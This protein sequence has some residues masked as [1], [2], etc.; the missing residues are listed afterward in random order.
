[1]SIAE[2]LVTIA[3]NQ[4][5]VYEAGYA[6]GRN[7]TDTEKVYNDGV[8]DGKEAERNSFWDSYLADSSNFYQRF[9]GKGFSDDNFYPT[10]DI[11]VTGNASDL[12]RQSRIT[13]LEQRLKECGVV[14]D[15]S[16]V[17]AL[18]YAFNGSAVTRLPKIDISNCTANTSLGSAFASGSLV[19]IAELIVSEST[20]FQANTFGSASKLANLIITGTIYAGSF[21]VA[22]SPNLTNYSLKSIINALADISSSGNTK[23]VTFGTTNLSKLTD[24]DKAIATEKGWTLV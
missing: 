13:N 16:G 19:S 14:L 24:A 9:S 1:M 6:K 10:K 12:F 15:T 20:L 4:Q 5:R 22:N 18:T 21:T 23:T 2:K 3:E 8:A 11:V 7:E 17:T